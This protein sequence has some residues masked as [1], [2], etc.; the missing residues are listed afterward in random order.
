MNEIEKMLSEIDPQKPDCNQRIALLRRHME[1]ACECGVISFKEWRQLV[2]PVA[3][4]QARCAS[5]IPPS[6]NNKTVSQQARLVSDALRL[7]SFFGLGPAR[8]F[9]EQHGFSP[10]QANEL[11]AKKID[12]RK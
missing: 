7:Q 5:S 12:R 4:L 3:A 2:D 8:H 10:I 11:L 6:P 9:L 1:E